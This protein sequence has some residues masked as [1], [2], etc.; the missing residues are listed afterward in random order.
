MT[1]EDNNEVETPEGDQ[2]GDEGRYVHHDWPFEVEQVSS[3]ELDGKEIEMEG[4]DKKGDTDIYAGDYLRELIEGHHFN[5]EENIWVGYHS[6]D[7]K[8]FQEAGVEHDALFRHFAF[9]GQTGYGKSTVL[10]NLM[11]QCAFADYG[12]C[13]IDPKGQDV[14]KLL[15]KLPEH[16][17]EDVIWVE[18]GGTNEK[19]VGFNFFD[20]YHEP[21]DARRHREVSEIVRD[22]VSLL[23]SSKSSWGATIESVTEAVARELV[24]AEEPFTVMDLHSVITDEEEREFFRDYFSEKQN[25][26]VHPMREEIP[27]FEQEDLRPLMKRLNEWVTNDSNKELISHRKSAI[28]ITE[29]VEEGKILLVRTSTIGDEKLQGLISTAIVRRIWSAIR[30]RDEMDESELE[31]YFVFADEFDKIVNDEMDIET[32]LSKARSFKLSMCMANQYPTQLPDNVK[33]AIMS[34]VENLFT[35]SPGSANKNDARALSDAFGV[36]VDQLFKLSK[37]KLV[38]D[39]TVGG[40]KTDTILIDTFPPYPPRRSKEKAEEVIQYSLDKYGVERMRDESA[41]DAGIIQQV[42]G[43]SK[44]SGSDPGEYKINEDG[45]KVTKRQILECIFTAGVRHGTRVI[46]NEDGWVHPD[47][48]RKE[49]E[50]YE[51]VGDIS[52]LANAIER[53]S[54]KEVQRELLDETFFKLG[55][56]GEEIVFEQNTGR[57]SSAGRHDHRMLIKKG[58]KSFTKLGYKVKVPEQQG[59]AQPDAVAVPPIRPIEESSTSKEARDLAEEL[60]SKYPR[61]WELFEDNILNIEAESTTLDT[62]HQTIKNLQK[63]VVEGNK[64]V[65]LVKDGEEEKG[66][67]DGYAKQ[68]HRILSDPPLV[69]EKTED[70]KIRYY[71][72]DKHLKLADGSTALQKVESGEDKTAPP[73]RWFKSEAGG[74]ILEHPEKDTIITRFEDL[75]EIRKPPKEKFNYSY[76]A[77]GGE[78]VKVYDKNGGVVDEFTTVDEM[79]DA[80]YIKVK[81]PMIP[82]NAFPDGKIPDED[83]WEIIVVPA[84]NKEMG[85]QVYRDGELED[86][87][88]ESE[89]I[90]DNLAGKDKTELP[91][92]TKQE[93]LDATVETVEETREQPKETEESNEEKEDPFA[94]PDY[95]D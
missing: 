73:T 81:R 7:V 59:S 18:P 56:D 15:Q 74:V 72:K 54:E 21:G 23:K 41:S 22:F 83:S 92:E 10:T 36:K 42:R 71:N 46:D 8:G 51:K 16:R 52:M 44:D 6:D 57:T 67:I 85:L 78:S 17:L 34:N 50:K 5:P 84:S 86:L 60:E 65:F 27:T 33:T 49:L 89:T 79:E 75:D 95:D 35:F 29:A 82:E 31:P 43:G 12:F 39:F 25:I 80:G 61:L 66:S 14:V 48:L 76:K 55:E 93:R 1:E 63:A 47:D 38:G 45:G 19:V 68:A 32:I 64:A 30:T 94:W 2:G 69:R 26:E 88:P 87:V 4:V 28:N 91:E 90:S 13:F 20:T 24:T 77:R 53:M 70:G 11:L 9:F 3:T 40:E 58:F 37:Y 62:P